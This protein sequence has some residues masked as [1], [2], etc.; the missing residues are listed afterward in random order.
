MENHTTKY[1][2]YRSFTAAHDNLKCNLTE[3]TRQCTM[4]SWCKS[5]SDEKINVIFIEG[6]KLLQLQHS[7][8][9]SCK[10]R[11]T[12]YCGSIVFPSGYHIQ[13]VRKR[14]VLGSS[15]GQFVMTFTFPF[16]HSCFPFTENTYGLCM[17]I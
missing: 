13:D 4:T 10:I 11:I 16:L 14:R 5:S 6:L 3:P 1:L 15:L 8:N 2:V 12:S 17:C 9:R 7:P